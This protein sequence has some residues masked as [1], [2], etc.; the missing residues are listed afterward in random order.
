MWLVG[1]PG[2]G[3]DSGAKVVLQA[4]QEHVAPL[5]DRTGSHSWV[6][7]WARLLICILWSRASFVTGNVTSPNRSGSAKQEQVTISV[8][9]D[10]RFAVQRER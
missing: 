8:Q 6:I 1:E 9:A 4:A 7:G 2:Q 5:Q 3:H 10:F